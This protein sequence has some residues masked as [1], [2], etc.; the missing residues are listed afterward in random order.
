MTDITRCC[1]DD[2][3]TNLGLTFD[4]SFAFYNR[5]LFGRSR[6]SCICFDYVCSTPY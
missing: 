2:G 6:P 5:L 3:L 4:L 1:D